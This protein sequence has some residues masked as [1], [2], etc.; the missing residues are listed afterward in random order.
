MVL[1][2]KKY[3]KNKLILASVLVIGL[4]PALALAEGKDPSSPPAP[5][6][7]VQ[8]HESDLEFMHGSSTASTTWERGSSTAANPGEHGNKEG[9]IKRI[10]TTTPPG[11]IELETGE[12]PE[13]NANASSSEEHG[14]GNGGNFISA[15]LNWLF[16]QPGTT[17]IDQIKTEIASGTASTTPPQ[18]PP[19]LLHRLFGWLPWFK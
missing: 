8:Y 18:G 15:F 5:S 19:G 14:K 3:M 2:K 7:V 13:A 11:F 9:I 1:N 17:T 6:W 12:N 16:G 4:A 10:G